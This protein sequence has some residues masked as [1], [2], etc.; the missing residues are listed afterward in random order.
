MGERLLSPGISFG[1]RNQVRVLIVAVGIVAAIVLLGW[2]FSVEPMK[3]IAPGLTSMNPATAICLELCCFT[4]WAIKDGRRTGFRGLAAVLAPAIVLYVG[5]AKLVDLSLGTS[6]CP[7]SLLFASQLNFGQAFPSRMAPNAAACFVLLAVA[8][9]VQGRP[10][11][12]RFLHPQWLVTPIMCLSLAG[13]LGYAYD[14]SGFYAVK[15]YIPMALHTAICFMLLAVAIILSRPGEGY[16]RLIPRDSP[17][18]RSY[19]MLL[20]A[21]VILPALVGGLVLYGSDQGWLQGRGTGTA[22]VAVLTIL[23]MTLLAFLN[24]VLLNR[25]ERIRRTGELRL[26]ELVAELDQRNRELEQEILE[27]KHAEERAAHQATHDSL[28]A[29]PNRML[30]LEHLENAIARAMRHG[31][32]FALLYI[33]ID[34][35]KPVNDRYGHQAGDEVLKELARR[36]EATVRKVDTVARLGGDEFAAIMDAPVLEQAALRLAERLSAA[37]RQPYRLSLPGLAQPFE[38]M[39]GMSVGIALFPGHADGLDDLVRAADSAMYRAKLI[40]KSHGRSPNIEIAAVRSQ[41]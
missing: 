16:M 15:N 8:L 17:G 24:S 18:A 39:V 36:L 38:V 4:L 7:D 10:W 19:A 40:G 12:P 1:F 25:A 41:A 2:I 28:T 33:D 6:L 30:F 14:T 32:A 23:G 13:I 11:W 34:H 5:L 29:L 20:P 22:I 35:F 21:C 9:S 3:R 31:D 37:V 27:R 26:R